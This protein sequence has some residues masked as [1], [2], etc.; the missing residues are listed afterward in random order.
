MS[1]RIKV[2]CPKCGKI[3]SVPQGTL[4]IICDC[5]LYCEDGEKPT[6]CTLTAQTFSGN[7][8]LFTGLHLGHPDSDDLLHRRYYC[9]VHGKYSYKQPVLIEVDAEAWFRKRAPNGMREIGVNGLGS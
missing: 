6:D 8:N 5:H 2:K 7:L 1:L 4:D 3:W 9:S